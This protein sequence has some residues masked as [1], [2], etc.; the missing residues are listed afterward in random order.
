MNLWNI[1]KPYEL[2]TFYWIHN[3]PHNSLRLIEYTICLILDFT[4]EPMPSD[5]ERAFSAYCE[6]YAAYGDEIPQAEGQLNIP[7]NL[8]KMFSCVQH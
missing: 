8:S 7:G 1:V 6:Q 2:S 4:E 5:E 3:L